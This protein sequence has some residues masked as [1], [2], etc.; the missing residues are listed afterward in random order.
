MLCLEVPDHASSC[1]L[2]ANRKDALVLTG[3]RDIAV[4]EVPDEAVDGCEPAVARRRRV[5][6]RR[7]KVIEKRENGLHPDVVELEAL[8]RAPHS[9]R[10]EEEEE[11]EGVPIGADGMCACTTRAPQMVAEIGLYLA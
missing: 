7:L 6:S 8:D 11:P 5:G 3:S 2:R 10:E 9:L 1:A 4:E